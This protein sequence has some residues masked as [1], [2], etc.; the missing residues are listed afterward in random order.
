LTDVFWK[1]YH[2]MAHFKCK[3]PAKHNDAAVAA[4][5]AVIQKENLS[6]IKFVI[7]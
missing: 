4:H 7:D 2:I 6:L 1:Y 3:L 5:I